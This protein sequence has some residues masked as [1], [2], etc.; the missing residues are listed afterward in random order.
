MEAIDLLII[1]YP[2]SSVYQYLLHFSSFFIDPTTRISWVFLATAQINSQYSDFE[3]IESMWELIPFRA[4]PH[5]TQQTARR[6]TNDIVD[7]N[8]GLTLMLNNFC[9]IE[10]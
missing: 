6:E 7:E 10:K 1:T 8:D 9:W 2:I 3:L 5:T 4:S